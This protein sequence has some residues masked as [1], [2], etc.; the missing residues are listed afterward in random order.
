MTKPIH[1]TALLI[2]LLLARSH[3]QGR[4][5]AEGTPE[6][7][8]AAVDED[9]GHEHDDA[10]RSGPEVKLTWMSI[11]N[12][13]FEVGDLRIIMDG[14]FT[15]VPGPPFF[16]GGGGGLAFTLE[17]FS[18]DRSTIRLVARAIGVERDRSVLLMT[19][20]SH[21]DHSF[22]TATWADLTGART[23]IGPRSTCFQ[24][25]AEGISPSRCRVVVGGETLNLGDGVKV[26]VVR[27]NHSGSHEVAPEQHDPVELDEIPMPDPVT[28]GLRAGVAEDFPNG[29][30]GR[31]FL[32]TAEKHGRRISWFWSNSSSAVDL[33]V[34]I[35]VDGIDYGAPIDNIA[36]AMA[37]AGLDSVDLWIGTQGAPIAQL[38]APIIKPKAYIPHHWDGLFNPFLP[39]LPF[40]YADPAL[41][42]YLT[43]QDIRLLPEHQYMDAYRL[44]VNGIRPVSNHRI[45]RE[46][47]FSD[48]QE[49]PEGALAGTDEGC[50]P[51]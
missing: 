9:A 30:G 48:V 41:E 12:W 6:S 16:F 51:R 2:V 26:W 33:H 46:L 39:G 50:D 4:V 8:V 49:F 1:L 24:A 37:D 42:T 20:H 47:G 17:P 44:D 7:N 13:F 25:A 36:L 14:Y 29:G 5:A 40:R 23:I 35:V 21:F 3:A 27:F 43:A 18:P 32:F 11:A 22:D 38:V 19:G 31:A 45:K 15:R 28:G 34:P 10:G